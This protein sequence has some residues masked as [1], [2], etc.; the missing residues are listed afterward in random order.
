ML[1]TSL[2]AFW[3]QYIHIY[4]YIIIE[5]MLIFHWKNQI[6]VDKCNIESVSVISIRA[7]PLGCLINQ[8]WKFFWLSLVSLYDIN[9]ANYSKIHTFDHVTTNNV[10]YGRDRKPYWSSNG[11]TFLQKVNGDLFQNLS[12]FPALISRFLMW[13]SIFQ[14]ISISVYSLFLLP[15]LVGCCQERS[16]PD[17]C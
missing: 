3:Y 5:K 7:G 9:Y 14:N 17:Q 12:W 6:L 2:K 10:Q 13:L 11:R 1:T 8:Y 16:E 4:I 15:F